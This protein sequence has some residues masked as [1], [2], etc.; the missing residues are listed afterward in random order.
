[1][2]ALSPVNCG[3]PTP[4]VGAITLLV[5][6]A[7]AG[8]QFDLAS[9][10]HPREGGIQLFLFQVQSFRPCGRVTFFAGTKKVTKESAVFESQERSR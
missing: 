9:A 8:I 5:I 2:A 10:R 6:P 1:M 7:K 4:E 3:M